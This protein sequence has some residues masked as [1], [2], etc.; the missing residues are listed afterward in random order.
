MAVAVSMTSPQ[1]LLFLLPL[2]MF[3]VVMAL[4]SRQ[5]ARSSSR[6]AGILLRGCIATVLLVAWAGPQTVE[7]VPRPRRLEI[8]IDVS[9]SILSQ[10]RDRA[11][12]SLLRHLS[13]WRDDSSPQDTVV[14]VAF[15]GE[16]EI[17]SS[18]LAST[19][20]AESSLTSLRSDTSMAGLAPNASDLTNALRLAAAGRRSND[21]VSRLVFTDGLGHSPSGSSL[22][23]PTPTLLIPPRVEDR[24]NLRVVALQHPSHVRQGDPLEFTLD[25][26]ASRAF[27]PTQ[28]LLAVDGEEVRRWPLEPKAGTNSLILKIAEWSPSLG[29]RSLRVS[30]LMDDAEPADDAFGSTVEVLPSRSVLLVKA[31]EAEASAL[32]EK[33]LRSREILAMTCRA[34]ELSDRL[35]AGGFPHDLV[36]MDKVAAGMLSEQDVVALEARVVDGMG[37]CVIPPPIRGELKSLSDS[38]LGR[39]LPMVG[40]SPLPIEEEKKDPE[41]E[42]APK[43]SDQDPDRSK[44][45]EMDAPTLALLLLIDKSSSMDESSRLKL[46]KAGA[47]ATARALHPDD[48][49]GVV[50]YNDRAIDVVPLQP[51]RNLPSI[52]R[53]I[54]SIQAGGPTDIRRALQFARASMA[55]DNSAIKVVILLTDGHT[56]P[57]DPKPL[58]EKMVQEGVTVHTVGVGTGFDVGMLTQIASFGGGKG[59]IPARTSREIPQVMVD[60]A[61]DVMDANNTR[62]ASDDVEKDEARDIP[63]TDHQ[64]PDA[65]G[66]KSAPTQKPRKGIVQEAIEVGR[67]VSYVA[68]I[69]WEAAPPLQ[70]IHPASLRDGAWLSLVTAGGH[71]LVAHHVVGEG[72]VSVFAF[73]PEYD[74]G[75][76]WSEWPDTGPFLSRH[77]EFLRGLPESPTLSLATRATAEGLLVEGTLLRDRDSQQSGMWTCRVTKGGTS[78]I[79][80]VESADGFFF[81]PFATPLSGFVDVEVTVADSIKRRRVFL[82]PPDEVL[83]RN[84]DLDRLRAWCVAMGEQ[85]LFAAADSDR[86]QT[87]DAGFVETDQRLPIRG[88]EILLVLFLLEIGLRRL[89]SSKKRE[90]A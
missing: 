58:L 5:G 22:R 57:F 2:W 18:G 8:V 87:S 50:V 29:T 39:L 32:L 40:L 27:E 9:R 83:S 71:P 46:A 38:P 15:A 51:A 25:Y 1:I 52:E 81:L 80:P 24:D 86:L 31:D 14:V 41:E 56:P 89:D 28:C 36:V 66:T 23:E 33:V 75:D 60:V 44:E 54:S 17:L 74:G 43:L 59:P 72:L 73:D 4:T 21:V 78:L 37:L 45:E 64:L 10:D 61:S 62:R 79:A 16:S 35:S 20:A 12:K 19:G 13:Q 77:L 88:M 90:A 63:R 30:L 76:L 11:V 55:R 3:V 69:G 84:I 42:G 82:P 26:T 7:R 65:K 49:I 68:D 48:S 53:A 47:I 6:I 70:R 34:S 67:M 85:T